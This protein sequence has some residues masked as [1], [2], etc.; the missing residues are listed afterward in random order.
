MAQHERPV[1]QV[2]DPELPELGLL[3]GESVSELIEAVTSQAGGRVLTARPSQVR[4]VPSRALVVQ[5]KANID[6]G[7][8]SGSE[9]TMVASVGI[10]VPDHVPRVDTGDSE[11]AIWRYPFDPFL[12][13]L[14][15]AADPDKTSELLEILGAPNRAVRLRRRSYR[16]GRRAVI[17]VVAPDTRIYLKVVR[18]EKVGGLQE[19]HKRLVDHVPIPHSYGWS[20]DLGLVAM[21][22]LPGRTVRRA[23]EVGSRK[24]PDAAQIIGLLDML[25]EA[26]E[27]SRQVAGPAQRA[28][29]HADLLRQVLPELAGRLDGIVE[30][31]EGVD[32]SQE[33][34]VHG[35][36]HSSQILTKGSSITGL[37]DVDTV[38][39]G[40]RPDD[41][42]GLLGHIS[43][44]SLNSASRR[45]IERYGRELISAFDPTTDPAELRLRTAA[46]VLGF[47]TG[48]FRVQQRHWVQET[49]RRVGLAERWVQAASPLTL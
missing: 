42:A 23:M 49:R 37:I 27:P 15:V 25:A 26:P 13:G 39:M 45:G 19:N 48:P 14:A 11:I 6:W 4:Y 47:A 44:L 3:L 16:P 46:T 34:A 7:G 35:D 5:Y 9:E 21:Q 41:L 1:N 28:T 18:P 30:A 17:E 22:A 31:V 33:T 32:R 12:P 2:T 38:G 8:A 36:F 24:L 10:R 20:K 29:D 43:T 40:A